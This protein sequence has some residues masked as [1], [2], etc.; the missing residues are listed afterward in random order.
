MYS[1]IHRPRFP[2]G[3]E[4]NTTATIKTDHMQCNLKMKYIILYNMNLSKKSAK[5]NSL[6]VFSLYHILKGAECSKSLRFRFYF[7]C[8]KKVA[9][10]MI[11]FFQLEVVGCTLSAD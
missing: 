5:E 11:F 1:L 2:W 7:P 9:L 3:M 4:R 6:N 10:R 8:L